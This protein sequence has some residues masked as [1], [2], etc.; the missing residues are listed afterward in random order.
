MN[1]MRLFPGRA[2]RAP[3]WES[4]LRFVWGFVWG[5]RP[6]P[7]PKEEYPLKQEKRLRG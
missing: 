7:L 1:C 5:F 2:A 4:N 3:A 6:V